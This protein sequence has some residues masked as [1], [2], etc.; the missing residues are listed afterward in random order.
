[1]NVNN[2]TIKAQEALQ[3]AFTI[4][5]GYTHQAVETGHLLKAVLSTG[6]SVTGF[7][8]GKFGINKANFEQV[9]DKIV[10]GLSKSFG[11]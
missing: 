7:I 4:A 10:G 9:V 3:Q 8:L 6:E 1:M 5:S 2:L 11:W